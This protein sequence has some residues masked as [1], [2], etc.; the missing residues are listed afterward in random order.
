M[1]K[2]KITDLNDSRLAVTKYSICFY[3]LFVLS[4]LAPIA[5]SQILPIESD[6]SFNPGEPFQISALR[7]PL[8]HGGVLSDYEISSDK[9]YVVYR[10]RNN[11]S[12]EIDLYAASL[13]FG[14]VLSFT[15]VANDE[16]D[17]D[18][19]SFKIS[20]DSSKIVYVSDT[21]RGDALRMVNIDASG[22]ALRLSNTQAEGFFADISDYEI[23]PDSSRVVYRTDFG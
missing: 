20:S 14:F 21:D 23:S 10:A 3:A 18:V 17:G 19:T 22:S 1:T 5:S 15:L 12:G 6:S 16:G 8:S 2:N 4:C 9:K 13:E 11:R 7:Q